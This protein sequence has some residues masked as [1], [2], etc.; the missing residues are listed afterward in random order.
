[1]NEA[2]PKGIMILGVIGI[3]IGLV[4]LYA[5]FSIPDFSLF[6]MGLHSLYAFICISLAL[7]FLSSGIGIFKLKMWTRTLF[8]YSMALY[9]VIGLIGM[10]AF[11]LLDFSE[12]TKGNFPQAIIGWVILFILPA[13][14]AFYY[15]TREEIKNLFK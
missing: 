12:I 11:K 7:S 6:P 15:F 9:T 5:L 3:I 13:G 2:R 4:I 1:M 8:L 10:Y 14:I